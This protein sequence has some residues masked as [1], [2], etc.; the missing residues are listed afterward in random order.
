MSFETWAMIR[1][2]FEASFKYLFNEP[3]FV[4]LARRQYDQRRDG[5][6]HLRSNS[7]VA[8]SSWLREWKARLSPRVVPNSFWRRTITTTNALRRAIS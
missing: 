1:A 2:C 7:S 5:A 6:R 4:G 3:A 8:V